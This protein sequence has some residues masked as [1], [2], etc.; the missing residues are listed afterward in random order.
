MSANS[1]TNADADADADTPSLSTLVFKSGNTA[2]ITGSSSGIGKAAARMCAVKGMIVYMLDV[3]APMLESSRDEIVASSSSSTSED[4]LPEDRVRSMVVDVADEAAMMAAAERVDGD[5]HFLFNNAAVHGGASA[6]SRDNAALFERTLAVN[7]LGLVHGCNAFLPRMTASRGD[8][9]VAC[10]GSK[11]GIT[12]PPGN[13]CYNVSKAAAKAY[14]EGLEHELRAGRS[15]GRHGVRSALLVPG[16]TNTQIL[17]KGMRDAHRR[18]RGGDAAA[19]DA[20]F[21]ESQVFFHE[22]KPADDAWS[23]ERVVDFLLEEVD[24]GRFYVIC[25]DNDVDRETDDLRMTWTM[26]DITENRPP[27]SR[28]HPDHADTFR[29]YLEKNRASKQT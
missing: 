28:W 15:E 10:V 22:N 2:V 8:S 3:D 26:R 20:D 21:D 5:V 16:W 27:L 13:L 14:A 24:R 23:P 4:D 1:H 19:A 25:P 18:E 11:Q 9:L 7:A 12:M 17:Y 6:L 29:D